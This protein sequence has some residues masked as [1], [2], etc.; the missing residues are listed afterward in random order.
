[1]LI[2]PR[3]NNNYCVRLDKINCVAFLPENV[4][5]YY[6]FNSKRT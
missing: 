1:M 4:V 5:N 6:Y 3:K 2:A